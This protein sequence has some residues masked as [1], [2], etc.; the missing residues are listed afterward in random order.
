MFIRHDECVSPVTICSCTP[1]L[2]HWTGNR[3][4]CLIINSKYNY[5]EG[6]IYIYCFSSVGL[7]SEVRVKQ[8]PNITTFSSAQ[9]GGTAGQGIRCTTD[10]TVTFNIGKWYFPDGSLVSTSSSQTIY[11]LRSAGVVTLYQTSS[12]QDLEGLYTCR[13]P[14][15]TGAE[16]VLYLGLYREEN[17]ING[18]LIKI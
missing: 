7:F 3:C 13:I 16:H 14:D 5:N 17:Y 2:H 9:I 12:I 18:M 1:V 4:L 10:D 15:T 11:N 6:Y 8:L